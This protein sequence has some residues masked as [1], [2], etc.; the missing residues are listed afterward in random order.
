MKPP[1]AAVD[2]AAA[3]LCTGNQDVYH[4]DLSPHVARPC[5]KCTE[6]A[7]TALDAAMPFLTP[8]NVPRQRYR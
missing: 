1:A 7:Q 2:A 3:A 6:D 4:D 8:P 5:Q